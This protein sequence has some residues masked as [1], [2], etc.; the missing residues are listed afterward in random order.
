M[1]CEILDSAFSS[2]ELHTFPFRLHILVG[3]YMLKLDFVQKVIDLV[4]VCENLT[5]SITTRLN[6]PGKMWK[7][8]LESPGKHT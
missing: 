6:S 4:H 2:F 7:M 5:C 1:F 8:D 3:L